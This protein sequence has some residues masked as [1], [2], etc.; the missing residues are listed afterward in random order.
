MI[1]EIV[2]AYIVDYHKAHGYAPTYREIAV[3]LGVSTST[4]NR[5]MKTLIKQGKLA[6]EHIGSAR[7]IRI[8]GVDYHAETKENDAGRDKEL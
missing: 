7:A 2:Y 8:E 5:A 4:V 1:Y 6:T 3:F